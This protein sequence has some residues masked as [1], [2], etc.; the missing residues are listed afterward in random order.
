MVPGAKPKCQISFYIF[1]SAP[2]PRLYAKICFSSNICC[3]AFP[4]YY[5]SNNNIIITFFSY[6]GNSKQ[7][8]KTF[9]ARKI[10]MIRLVYIIII[11]SPPTEARFKNF[12]KKVSCKHC[13]L[14]ILAVMAV[15]C[16][17]SANILFAFTLIFAKHP[18]QNLQRIS[19][20]TSESFPTFLCTYMRRY[21]YS[22]VR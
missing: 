9:K 8:H 14:N 3:Y 11:R 6:F 22:K 18:K 1:P 12:I 2:L 19:F 7:Y 5:Q 17:F 21:T 16:F 10:G 13:C 15:Y 20:G 4:G